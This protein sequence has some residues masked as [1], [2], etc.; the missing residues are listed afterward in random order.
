MDNEYFKITN[1]LSRIIDEEI[2]KLIALYKPATENC[3]A[4]MHLICKLA[5]LKQKIKDA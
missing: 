2:A 5:I 3:A 1:H 4:D